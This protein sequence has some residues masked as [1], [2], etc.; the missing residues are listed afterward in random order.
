[1]MH[2]FMNS[3]VLA[4]HVLRAIARSRGRVVTVEDVA[5]TVGARRADVRRVVARLHEEGFVDALRMRPTMT[6]LALASALR[7]YKLKDIRADV[8]FESKVA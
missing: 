1:M 3:H 4:A 7:A 5:R 2:G 8:A 6:G